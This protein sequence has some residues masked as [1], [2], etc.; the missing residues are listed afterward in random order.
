MSKKKELLDIAKNLYK[1]D[2][3]VSVDELEER[4]KTLSDD[5]TYYQ[6]GKRQYFR[7]AHEIWHKFCKIKVVETSDSKIIGKDTNGENI[8]YYE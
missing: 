3:Q 8:R 5:Y 4:W 7:I 2:L 1:A 6:Y